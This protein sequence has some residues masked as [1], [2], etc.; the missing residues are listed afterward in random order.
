M[1]HNSV[2]VAS[3]AYNHLIAK[4]SYDNSLLLITELLKYTAL[5]ST[6]VDGLAINTIDRDFQCI[7]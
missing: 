4:V 2:I 7:R 1:S 6:V 5:H 3:I